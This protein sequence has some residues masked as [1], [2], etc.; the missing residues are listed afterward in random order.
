MLRLFL[1]AAFVYSSFFNITETESVYSAV[2][3]E[4]LNVMK[5]EV[6]LKWLEIGVCCD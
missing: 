3:N 6:R 1:Y 5:S 2:R 4:S